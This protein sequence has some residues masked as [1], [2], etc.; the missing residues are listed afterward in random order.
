MPLSA[1][2]TRSSHTGPRVLPASPHGLPKLGSQTVTRLFLSRPPY[3]H[4]FL[5]HNTGAGRPRL[6]RSPQPV[7]LNSDGQITISNL[8][9]FSQVGT[10]RQPL[11]SVRR[12]VNI[13]LNLSLASNG[14]NRSPSFNPP[15]APR[16]HPRRRH[17]KHPWPR[18]RL[19]QWAAHRKQINTRYCNN[20][21]GTATVQGG[22]ALAPPPSP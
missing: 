22:S 12:P 20:H 7:D 21:E 15:T 13:F 5:S 17:G 19:R 9:I 11:I 2:E 4:S 18:A 16:P 10:P 1:R 14:A 3:I 6:P 8:S